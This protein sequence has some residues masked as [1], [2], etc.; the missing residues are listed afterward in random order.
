MTTNRETRFV[1]T[2]KR[3]KQL[4]GISDRQIK[5]YIEDA[6]GCWGFGSDPEG[7]WWQIAEAGVKVTK[8]RRRKN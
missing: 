7:E 1:V 3:T 4:E 8:L 2:F 6:V 5:N